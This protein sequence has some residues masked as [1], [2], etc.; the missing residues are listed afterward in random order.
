[1]I[2]SVLIVYEE[3]LFAQGLENIINELNPTVIVNKCVLYDDLE[4]CLRDYPSDLIIISKDKCLDISYSS[5]IVKKVNPN[6]MFVVMSRSFSIDDVKKFMEYSVNGALC[7]KYSIAK[8]RGILSLLLM[9]ENY[10]PSEILP[11]HNN[12]C[13]TKQQ[14]KI[15][16]L[17]RSGLSNKQIAYELNLSESTIKTHMSLMMKKLNVNNRVQVIRKALELGII[18]Y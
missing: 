12:N 17:L 16:E 15:I 3:E 5:P 6:A 11:N 8:I 2:E 14:I 18:Q 13:L 9:G 4:Q 7:K 10:Y 1:M